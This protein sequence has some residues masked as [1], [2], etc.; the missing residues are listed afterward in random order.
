MLEISPDIRKLIHDYQ[1]WQKSLSPNPDAIN[2]KVDEIASKVASFYERFREIVDW[3]E[4]HLMRR[5]AIE[6]ILKRRLLL[7]I[8]GQQIA[9]P[10]VFELIRGGYFAG[11]PIEKTKI[12]IIQNVLDKYIFILGNLKKID[13]RD[14]NRAELY[15]DISGIAACEI[16]EILDPNFYF[17]QNIL[18]NFTETIM[19]ARIK[20]GKKAKELTGITKEEVNTQIYVAVQQALFRLDL[21]IISYNLIKRRYPFWGNASQA[22]IQEFAQNVCV[23]LEDIEKTLNHPLADKFYK[24]AE[25]YDTVYLLLD[26]IITANPEKIA[27]EISDP[28]VL[29]KLVSQAYSLRLETLRSRLGRAAFYSALSIFLTNIFSLYVLEFPFA[30]YVM[31]NINPLAAAIDVIGPTFLMLFLTVTVKTPPKENRRLVIEEVRKIVYARQAEESYEVE[32]YPKGNVIFRFINNLLYA[33]SFCVCFGVILFVL[34]K[35]HYPPLSCVLLI[36]FTCLIAFAGTRIRNRSMELCVAEKKENF[37]QI[38][39]DLFSLPVIR[40]GKWLLARWKKIN[41][42]GV[43][44]NVLIDTPFLIFV[45][46][47]EQWRYFLKEKKEDIR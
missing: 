31:G 37:S 8:N 45:E 17:K 42:L 5:V 33:I 25:R 29:D 9:E 20:I 21:P 3:K 18:L 22:Q 32:I 11:I 13:I 6:R 19:R 24:I 35:L 47:L 38:I 44:F 23:I 41:I 1:S 34:Y 7:R 36:M 14:K 43:I 12:D 15:A 10:F 4:Q 26:D 28:N 39:V 46:F 30:K 40:L 27:I 2:I 16:E